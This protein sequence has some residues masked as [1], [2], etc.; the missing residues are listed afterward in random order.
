M[1]YSDGITYEHEATGREGSYFPE[2][3]RFA[4]HS[5]TGIT[6]HHPQA[7]FL[8][9]SSGALSKYFWNFS[10]SSVALI[11]TTLR[12]GRF[13]STSCSRQQCGGQQGQ[14]LRC[15]AKS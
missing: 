11:T 2:S 9:L 14:P 7:G 8:T 12:S 5:S 4:F 10:A 3:P 6:D 15:R 13:L 1:V